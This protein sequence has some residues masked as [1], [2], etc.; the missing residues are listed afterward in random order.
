MYKFSK[1]FVL[2]LFLFLIIETT[3]SLKKKVKIREYSS[4]PIAEESEQRLKDKNSEC[5][6]FFI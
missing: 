6:Y 4:N 3:T 2:C 5:K 1:E